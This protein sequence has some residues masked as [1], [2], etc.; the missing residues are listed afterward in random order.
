MMDSAERVIAE[1]DDSEGISV[2][3]VGVRVE[4]RPQLAVNRARTSGATAVKDFMS[5]RHRIKK[6]LKVANRPSRVEGWRLDLGRLEESIVPLAA[7]RPSVRP[8][9]DAPDWLWYLR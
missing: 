3:A 4:P 9:V 7:E 2:G 6:S 8:L 5:L 1:G